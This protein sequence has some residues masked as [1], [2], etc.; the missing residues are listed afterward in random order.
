MLLEALIAILIFSLG[1][2]A[3][4]GIQAASI[5][6]AAGA[7][8]RSR[9]AL[10]ADQLVGEMW[11]NGGKIGDLATKFKSPEGTAYV[12]WRDKRVMDA[13][14]LPGVDPDGDTAPTVNITPGGTI[15]GENRNAQVVITLFWRTHTMTADET[16]HQHVVTSHISR[17]P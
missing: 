9:A 1:I 15:D 3:V 14:G 10:L 11:A 4:I 12:A 16:P 5:R 6:M 7:Q 13:D 17:N 8:L 2:L